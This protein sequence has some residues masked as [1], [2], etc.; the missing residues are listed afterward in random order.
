MDLK[1]IALFTQIIFASIFLSFMYSEIVLK[2]STANFF[3][4]DLSNWLHI[5]LSSNLHTFSNYSENTAVSHHWTVRN[6]LFHPF[7]HFSSLFNTFAPGYEP[8][9]NKGQIIHKHCLQR[10]HVCGLLETPA[11]IGYQSYKKRESLRCTLN[12]ASWTPY[13]PYD[14]SSYQ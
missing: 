4:S 2:L 10:L 9:S 8:L 3:R 7:S 5:F 11:Y 12:G 14:R 13:K 6:S 1:I